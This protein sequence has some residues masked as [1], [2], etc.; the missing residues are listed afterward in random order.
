M[1]NVQFLHGRV[2]FLPLALQGIYPPNPSLEQF[3][4]NLETLSHFNAL[5]TTEHAKTH[6]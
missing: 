2:M 5:N 1:Y 6:T 4:S 3:K